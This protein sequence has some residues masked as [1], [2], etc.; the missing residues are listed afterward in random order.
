MAQSDGTHPGDDSDPRAFA[1]RW[2]R[3]Q[4]RFWQGFREAGDASGTQ[5]ARQAWDEAC[6]RWWQ[7]VADTVPPP[8]A[9][10]LK[11]ALDQTRWWMSLAGI[12]GDAAGAPSPATQAL[13]PE[14]LF[15]TAADAVRDAA[16]GADPFRDPRY[17]AAFRALTGLLLE[18]VQRSLERVRER[19]A[20]EGARTP[21][22][23]HA[24][25]SQE[26][27][28]HYLRAAASDEFVRAVGELVNA[29]VA[30]MPAREWSTP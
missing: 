25:Y 14:R 27:E 19:L 22:A 17:L 16:D 15:A 10:Q 3:E 13:S 11:S 4:Q 26:I 9:A 20:E 18:I 29:Q 6:E 8:L 12:S 5:R 28:Q 23:V 1:E 21:R 7:G 2:L 30:L 24:I